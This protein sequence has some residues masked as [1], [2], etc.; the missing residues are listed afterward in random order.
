MTDE[1]DQAGLAE[2]R[3]AV[4]A[5]NVAATGLDD[6]RDLCCLVRDESGELLAGLDGFTW[7]GYGMIEWLWV[8]ADRRGTGLGAALM[9]AA[10]AEALARGCALMRVNT[11]TFQAPGF[12][13]RLGYRELATADG[14]PAGHGEVFLLK[15]LRMGDR[16]A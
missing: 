12:Y 13:A 10:E 9:A 2:L 14:T 15:H 5:F 6:G 4:V 1:A 16:P 8:R 7:G 11:H 3:R